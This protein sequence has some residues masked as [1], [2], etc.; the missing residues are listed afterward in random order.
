MKRE[1]CCDMVEAP[2]L[3]G[4]SLT[5]AQQHSVQ[6]QEAELREPKGE[7]DP[8]IFQKSEKQ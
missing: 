1:G 5:C 8:S 3:R 4:H 7:I 6:T 2:S